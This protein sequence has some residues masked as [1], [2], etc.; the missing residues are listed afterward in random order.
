MNHE[1]MNLTEHMNLHI[2]YHRRPHP[3]DENC[4]SKA[5]N[6][7]GDNMNGNMNW[8]QP[9]SGATGSRNERDRRQINA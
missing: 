3:D 5:C 7:N 8:K 2:A 6:L 9:G 4:Y 1:H